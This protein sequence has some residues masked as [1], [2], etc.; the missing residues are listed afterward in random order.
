MK[1]PDRGGKDTA[2]FGRRNGSLAAFRIQ[3]EF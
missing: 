3:E 1:L 2:R